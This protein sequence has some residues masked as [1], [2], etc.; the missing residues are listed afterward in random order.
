M[1]L[2]WLN[3][4]SSAACCNSNFKAADKPEIESFVSTDAL[5]VIAEYKTHA[6][7]YAPLSDG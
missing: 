6:A 3:T 2:V 4:V 5:P 7:R 1:S